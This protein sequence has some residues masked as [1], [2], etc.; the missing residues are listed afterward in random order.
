[1]ADATA[2]PCIYVLAGT[3]GAGKS[4]LAGATFLRA[5][6]E[7]FNPD[8]AARLILARNPGLGQT[9]ANSAAWHQG[10]RLLERAIAERKTFAFETTLGGTTITALLERALNAGIAVRVWYVGLEGP[11][12]H[13]ARVRARV[14]RGGH[15][16]PVEQVRA[17]YDSS[18]LNLVRLLPQLTELRVYD[19]S[20]EADPRAGI[21]PEPK[22]ILH[23][24]RRKIVRSCPLAETPV[25]AKPILAAAMKAS[26]A[27]Q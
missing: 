1:M 19:N 10:R 27:V 16:I 17:R 4:S 25:W 3:N 26:A 24:R 23:M 5:G 7:Y 12:L 22:L 18:R 13:V 2:D 11:E 14:A 9:E 21:A 20:V 8:Q 6:V 15:D